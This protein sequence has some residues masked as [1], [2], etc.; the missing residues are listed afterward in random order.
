MFNTK[1]AQYAAVAPPD[2]VVLNTVVAASLRLS[3]GAAGWRTWPRPGRQGGRLGSRR[4]SGRG[5]IGGRTP[6]GAV[7]GSALAGWCGRNLLCGRVHG[8]GRRP[9][10]AARPGPYGRSREAGRLGGGATGCGGPGNVEP[11]ERAVRGG[12]TPR[13]AVVGGQAGGRT[14]RL[15]GGRSDRWSGG[16]V[17]GPRDHA[18][19]DRQPRVGRTRQS[20]AGQARRPAQRHSTTTG[21]AAKQSDQAERPSTTIE[22]TAKHHNQT[23]AQ[24]PQPSTWSSAATRRGG[25]TPRLS[26]GMRGAS[27]V[28]L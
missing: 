15:A 17:A 27:A 16:P 25:W 8:A 2:Q 22:H 12:S 7:G 19:Q 20:S 18:G 26:K 6:A 10:Q 13:L 9:R 5:W 3:F 1:R 28:S 23:H 11:G 21:A 24:T 4:R 14:G